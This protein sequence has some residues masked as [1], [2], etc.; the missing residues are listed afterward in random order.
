VIGSLDK[1][2]NIVIIE[3][4]NEFHEGTDIAH[5]RNMAE[6]ILILPQNMQLVLKTVKC[7]RRTFL[8]KNF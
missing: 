4:W 7:Q 3:T 6:H 5:S 1:T 2:M 8:E